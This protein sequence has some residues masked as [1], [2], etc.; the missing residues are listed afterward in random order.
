MKGK[1]ILSGLVLGWM[2]ITAFAHTERADSLGMTTLATDSALVV[3]ADT[4]V[5]EALPVVADSVAQVADSLNLVAVVDSLA[6]TDSVAIPDS[7]VQTTHL[8]VAAEGVFVDS[9]GVDSLGLAHDAPMPV[10]EEEKEP[11]K[12]YVFVPDS[13]VTLAD[14]IFTMAST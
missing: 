6:P 10:E 3:S 9:L 14:S 7:L 11:A 5:A 13:I 8:A 1:S 12:V 2:A 4:T